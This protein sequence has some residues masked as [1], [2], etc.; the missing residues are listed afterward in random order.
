MKQ[1]RIHDAALAA[2]AFFDSGRTLPLKKRLAALKRLEAQVEQRQKEI[3]EALRADLNKSPHE[4]FM[5][6]VGLVLSELRLAGKSL[7]RWAK[8]ERC[9]PSIAQM[10]GRA[11][12]YKQPFGVALV[13][14]PWNYPFQLTMNPLIG[15]VAAGNCALV[16]P[17]AYAPNTALVMQE[18]CEAAFEPGWVTVIQ[19]G[20]EENSALL[21]EKFDY[22]F[23]T[24]SVSVGRTVMQKA[25]ERLTPLTLELGGKSP[26][27][28]DRTADPALAARRLLFGKL[29]NA[30]QTCVAPDYVLVHS[31]R[32]EEL[33][34]ALKEELARMLPDEGY[35]KQTFPKIINEKHYQR[36]LGLLEGQQVL[37]GGQAYPETRQISPALVD[38]PAPASPLMQEEIFGPILPIISVDSLEAAI[39][40]VAAR[41]RPLSLYLFTSER[42]AEEAVISRLHFGGGCVN[43]TVL[44]LAGAR[45]PFGGVGDS[46][47]GRYHGKATFGSFTHHKSV[48]KKGRLIDIPFRY[49]P[50]K[51]SGKTLPKW[52]LRG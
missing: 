26:A 2:R 52:M 40:Y 32:K 17:S 21:E 3:L 1:P 15:A 30:G 42:A 28:V 27:I 24:G 25:A 41:P 8:P 31:A 19:G 34:K 35:L 36:L 48:L 4:G 13:M 49:H 20:R 10:P 43:D 44:H 9:R 5:A 29:I 7:R 18:I 51:D 45:L 46:G 47:L 11:Y 37:T 50:Y 6:E 22:I 16:K 14:S 33:V 38:E 39:A 23:F 12:V